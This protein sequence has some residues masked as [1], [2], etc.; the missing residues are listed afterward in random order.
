[1]R[2]DRVLANHGVGSRAIAN[3]LIR[4]GRVTVAGAPVRDPSAHAEPAQVCVDDEPIDH[5]AGVLVAVYKPTGY[6]VSHDDGEGPTVFSLLPPAWGDRSPRPEAVGR[7]DRD[8][9]GLLLVTDDHELLHRLTSP[10]HH[11]AK[12]YVARL[13]RPVSSELTDTFAAG[14]LVLRGEER[15]CAPATTVVLDPLTVEVTLTEGKYHQV[16]RMF[17][18]CGNHVEAL[19]RVAVG[20]CRLG[21]LAE[22]AWRDVSRD[23][24]STSP[25][26]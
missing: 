8:T 17:A 5:P 12:T 18:A 16:R 3:R 1:V 13:A 2:L 7:L 4:D 6:V 22:G 11:V 24:L 20:G 19:H 25:S 10:K 26:P 21:D 9:S 15:P 14:D 23:E